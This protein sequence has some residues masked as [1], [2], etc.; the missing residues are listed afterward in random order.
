[1][2][3]KTR[4]RI[5][6]LCFLLLGLC[7]LLASLTWAAYRQRAYDADIFHD[8]IAGQTGLDLRIHHVITSQPGTVRLLGVNLVDPENGEEIARCRQISL[9]D[10]PRAV[11]IHVPHIQIEADR[12]Q[13]LL[14]LLHERVLRQH[15]L[16]DRPVHVVAD[17]VTFVSPAETP[18]LREF[19]LD[20]EQTTQ[21]PEIMLT[22][23]WGGDMAGELVRLHLLREYRT[24][25][26]QTRI[27]LFTGKTPL[28]CS[29]LF[30]FPDAWAALAEHV[31]F[32]GDLVIVSSR[33]GLS[34]EMAG[35]LAKVPLE[36]IPSAAADNGNADP[37]IGILGTADI[38]LRQLQF[39]EG[40]I[41][42]LSGSL[43]GGPGQI[44]RRWL[45][46]AE[47]R[48]NM[49]VGT[50][51]DSRDATEMIGFDQLGI[52]VRLSAKEVHLRGAAA[53]PDAGVVLR[54]RDQP[55][56]STAGQPL[57]PKRWLQSLLGFDAEHLTAFTTH[58]PLARLF[59]PAVP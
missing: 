27:E 40:R 22:F 55:L 52:D 36:R 15:R 49:S 57:P 46:F 25:P 38:T 16:L 29:L 26:S 42:N 45:R 18:V 35:R 33:N 6:R 51:V 37:A 1:M 2:P 10:G 43:R 28:P 20:T 23:R 44:S 5:C 50:D 53:G 39:R 59:L 30:R 41:T 31:T 54:R 34:G 21:G 17:Q 58:A 11:G 13:R 24:A 48:L 47:E 9:C 12:F 19:R 32:Q 14:E 56:L 4:Q 3:S 8:W 7:P